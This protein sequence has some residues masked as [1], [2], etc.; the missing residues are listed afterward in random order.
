MVDNG[1][2]FDPDDNSVGINANGD[3]ASIATT[4]AP[5]GLDPPAESRFAWIDHEGMDLSA[6]VSASAQKPASAR[7]VRAVDLAGIFGGQ[8]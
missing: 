3:V 4:T 1:R 7:L 2:S 5:V 8:A 6:F